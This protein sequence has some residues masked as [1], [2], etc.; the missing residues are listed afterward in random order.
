MSIAITASVIGLKQIRKRMMR[1]GDKYKR[2]LSVSI[3]EKG[4]EIIGDSILEVPVKYGHLRGSAY[5]AP[6]RNVDSPEAEIGYGKKYAVYVHERTELTHHVGKAH[7]LR[8]P[9]NR[10][11][12]GYTRWLQRRTKGN[13]LKGKRIGMVSADIPRRPKGGKE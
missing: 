10:H 3:Y 5:V 8:D 1:E 11:M 7:Y 13:Y 9:F 12:S 6:P 2:A 4:L